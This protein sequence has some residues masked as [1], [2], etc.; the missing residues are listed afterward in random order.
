MATLLY[1]LTLFLLSILILAW[2]GGMIVRSL[3]K[4]ANYLHIKEFV[5]GFILM[6][7]STTLPELFVGITSALNKIPQLSLGNVI[8]S[9]IANLTLII[10]IPVLLAKGLHLKTKEIK[11]DSFLMLAIAT[12]PLVLNWDRVISRFDGLILISVFALYLYRTIKTTKTRKATGGVALNKKSL[13]VNIA[14]FI[15]GLIILFLSAELVVKYAITLSSMLNL[16]PILIGLVIIAIGTS[17]P[18][19]IFASQAV[20]KGHDEMA[21]GD[22]IGAVIFNT[23]LVLGITALIHPIVNTFFP[24]LISSLFLIVIAFIFVS[25]SESDRTITW[26]EGTALILFYV[27]FIIVEFTLKQFYF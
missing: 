8:G 3:S 9:N 4:I 12:L 2:S 24:F 15:M 26:L 10:G 7:F 14:I 5:I 22:I 17:L 1:S 16:A 18:E 23:T 6:A 11:K 27:L 13:Y 19:L 21:L 20:L 25:F